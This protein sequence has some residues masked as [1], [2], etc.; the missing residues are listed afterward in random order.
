MAFPESRTLVF[1]FFL[2]LVLK[3]I[4]AEN[5]VI[6]EVT[7]N[8]HPQAVYSCGKSVKLLSSCLHLHLL[9]KPISVGFFY[10]ER[11]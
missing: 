5:T 1:F 3:Q 10:L 6:T 11:D 8:S 9:K 2:V 7:T 4:N